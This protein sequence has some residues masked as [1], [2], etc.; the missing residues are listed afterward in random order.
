MKTIVTIVLF[1]IGSLSFCYGQELRN[2]EVLKL[3]DESFSAGDYYSAMYYYKKYIE[4]DSSWITVFYRYAESARLGNDY[5]VAEKL[6]KYVVEKDS[7]KKYSESLFR[8]A[9]ML[10]SNQKYYE[11]KENF[12][13]YY[14]DN[15]SK[16]NYFTSKSLLEIAACDSAV[17]F[18]KTPRLFLITHL[19]DNINTVYSEFGAVQ[20]NDSTIEFSSI[21]PE[22]YENTL[23]EKYS[24]DFIKI[25]QSEY[26]LVN[27]SAAEEFENSKINN[28]IDHNANIT[29]EQ[30]TKRLY[31]T[32]CKKI[33]TSKF[34]CEIYYCDF[35]N[36]KWQQPFRLPD[37]VNK[38][39]FTSTQPTAVNTTKGD[40]L[41]FSSDRPGGEGG[42]DLWY[43]IV[44]KKGECSDPVSLGETI[45]TPDDEI[46]PFYDPQTDTLYFSSNGHKG[47][48]NID[49]Y[50]TK[51]NLN[52]WTEPVNMGSPLNTSYNDFYFTV[53]K[54]DSIGYLTSNRP[55]SYFIKGETCCYD[56]YKWEKQIPKKVEVDTVKKDTVIKVVEDT[57]KIEK[58]IVDLLPLTLYFHNDEPDKKTWVNT[59]KRD[60]EATYKD[61]IAMI[62]EYKKEY[63]KDLDS[64]NKIKAENDIDYFFKGYVEDG[65]N[66]LNLFCELLLKDLETG[67]TCNV[68][69]KGYCSPL[70]TNEYNK[71][72][73]KRR[74]SSLI[75]YLYIYKNGVFIKYMNGKAENGGK[76]Q[77]IEEPIGEE[78]APKNVSDN[79]YDTKNSVYNPKA[80][81]ERKIKILYYNSEE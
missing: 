80:A 39:G 74:I 54:K 81:F 13:K 42:L 7:L 27:W 43:S 49:I 3:G 73:A 64:I 14:N 16:K 29:Y 10:K 28:K 51:G 77:F 21:R 18:E 48:G 26:R 31:F 37:N 52:K 78:A 57:I 45:N 20:T 70:T 22:N 17:K 23:G 71:H 25:Y 41:Y 65:Y 1:F 4:K 15:S 50:K 11:A 68:T 2:Y 9:E 61:Y 38:H 36:G 59:T 63:S 30:K 55:G 6:Y 58:R 60:Y 72:L 40:I 56:I 8:Y 75:N 69:V 33:N 12:Q 34:L 5:P 32:R 47:I 67:K 53:Y 62:P 79:Y 24:N 35:R 44:S 76:I 66:K 46:T 19:D